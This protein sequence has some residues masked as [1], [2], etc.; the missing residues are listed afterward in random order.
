MY[1]FT[2]EFTMQGIGKA[3][4]ILHVQRQILSCVYSCS[5][6]YWYP[7][8]SLPNRCP[9]QHRSLEL[10]LE[11]GIHVCM[12]VL[13]RGHS[14]PTYKEVISSVL[15]ECT[16]QCQ[17]VMRYFSTNRLFRQC[18][19]SQCVSNDDKKWTCLN[20]TPMAVDQQAVQCL[21]RNPKNL[22][23]GAQHLMY[24]RVQFYLPQ[25]T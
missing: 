4:C 14:L 24:I 23:S 3:I 9:K 13:P 8:E 1:I 5:V 6:Q 25:I 20:S 2:L 7:L 12:V 22:S 15:F 17:C 10:T 18:F 19:H 21:P 16:I 11:S